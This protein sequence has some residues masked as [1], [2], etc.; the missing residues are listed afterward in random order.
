MRS[1]SDAPASSAAPSRTRSSKRTP[2]SPSRTAPPPTCSSSAARRTLSSRARACRGSC[3]DRGLLRAPWQSRWVRR[4][5]RRRA[6]SSP[7]LSLTW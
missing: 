4:S 5:V 2:P 1:S 3:A 6:S 7:T